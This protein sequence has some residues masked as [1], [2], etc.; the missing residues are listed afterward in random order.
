MQPTL[1]TIFTVVNSSG[2]ILGYSGGA[3]LSYLGNTLD[4]GEH[5]IATSGAFTQEFAISYAAD[6]GKDITLQA[7][8]EPGSAVALVGGAGFLLGLG[9]RRRNARH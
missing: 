3:R 9:R 8:P 1:N 5:F 7:V 6:S 2:G 4:E